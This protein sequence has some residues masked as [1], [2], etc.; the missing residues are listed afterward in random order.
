MQQSENR[1]LPRSAVQHPNH[2]TER[3]G[4]EAQVE[5]F[6]PMALPHVIVQCAS[7]TKSHL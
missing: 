7:R 6:V 3:G 2:Q 1:S 5:P 4:Y